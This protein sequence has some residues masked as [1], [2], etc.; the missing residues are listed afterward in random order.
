MGETAEFTL[1]PPNEDG[2]KLANGM[3]CYLSP[4]QK[5]RKTNYFYVR[6]SSLCLQCAKK[7]YRECATKYIVYDG[8][9]TD[10]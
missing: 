1:D 9:G 6:V 5:F 7:I 2:E 3:L 10:K 4:Y 8:A